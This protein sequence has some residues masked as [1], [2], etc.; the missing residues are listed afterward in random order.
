MSLQPQGNHRGF[1]LGHENQAKNNG[2]PRG[3]S[4]L[5]TSTALTVILD[6]DPPTLRA[7]KR[8]WQR[9]REKTPPSMQRH[10]IM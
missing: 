2:T 8:E 7:R 9:E 5:A 4:G 6:Q 3:C 1:Q 10:I